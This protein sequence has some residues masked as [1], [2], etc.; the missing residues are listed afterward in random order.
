MK[1]PK[2]EFPSNVSI[3][4]VVSQERTTFGRFIEAAAVNNGDRL[5]SFTD[6][7][8]AVTWLMKN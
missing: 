8:K 4:L 7:N 1:E 5:K 6:T 3:A 2:H